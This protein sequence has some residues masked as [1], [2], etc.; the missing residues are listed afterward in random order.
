MGHLNRGAEAIAD[1]LFG[2]T[3]PSA[4]LPITYPLDTNGITTYDYK[5]IESAEYKHLY[6]F[7]HGLSYTKFEYSNLVLGSSE[8]VIP[9]SIEISVDV[10][11]IGELAGKETVL[12]FINDEFA[13]VSRPVRLLRGFQKVHLNPGEKITVKFK[14]S[15]HDL[16]F[17][18]QFNMRIVEPGHFNVYVEELNSRFLLKTE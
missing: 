16:S 6:P 9:N 5:P 8:I 2:D 15:Q 12:L 18:N 17:I 11:N 14:L 1:I 4:K 7:G 13:S 10:E 3:N